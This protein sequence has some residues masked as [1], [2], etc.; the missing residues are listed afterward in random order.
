M[1]SQ[2]AEETIANARKTTRNDVGMCLWYSQ[3]W[4]ET[5][6]RYP[7][8]SSQW[9]NAKYRHAGDRN[10]PPGAPVS[11]TGGSKG[12]GHSAISVGNGRVR[13]IDQ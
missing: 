8:A 5:P 6:H 12:Y 11:W 4:A 1:V 2:S 13:T 3:E 10:P 7:D 9:A